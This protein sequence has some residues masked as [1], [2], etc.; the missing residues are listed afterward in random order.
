[1]CSRR[2]SL[3]WTK[4]SDQL[5]HQS[6]HFTGGELGRVYV[7]IVLRDTCSIGVRDKILRSCEII[8][9]LCKGGTHSGDRLCGRE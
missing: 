5:K 2:T 9:T 4:I 1:M 3:K 7:G 8:T 6:E